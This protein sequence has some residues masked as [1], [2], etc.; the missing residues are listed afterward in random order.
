M[1]IRI[2]EDELWICPSFALLQWF[3]KLDLRLQGKLCTLKVLC[4]HAL[5]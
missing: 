5:Q 1:E 4:S 2:E 3:F